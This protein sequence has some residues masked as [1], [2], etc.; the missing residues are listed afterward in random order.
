MRTCLNSKT[1]VPV[2]GH[3]C[4]LM[5]GAGHAR[6]AAVARLCDG[7]ATRL[8]G[9]G[10]AARRTWV[11]AVEPSLA[12]VE[13]ADLAARLRCGACMPRARADRHL[14]E[15]LVAERHRSRI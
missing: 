11:S 9:A 4:E 8:A 15:L 12:A 2:N 13:G 1:G 3:L 10:M 14:D 5:A 6:L 7:D